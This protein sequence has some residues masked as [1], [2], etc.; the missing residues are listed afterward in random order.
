MEL[1]RH[2][3]DFR[4]FDFSIEFDVKNPK[5]NCTL[6]EEYMNF[7]QETGTFTNHYA[8]LCFNDISKLKYGWIEDWSFAGRSNGWFV[9][10]CN[11]KDISKITDNQFYKI[12]AIV[13]KYLE[14]YINCLNVFLQEI[15]KTP[16]LCKG[17]N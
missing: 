9:L 5:G 10:L 2:I 8:N 1:N 13:K 17:S 4:N 7:E 15:L 6:T 16:S 12:E 11:G 3:R 14:N